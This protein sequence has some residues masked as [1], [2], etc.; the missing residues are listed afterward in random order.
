MSSDFQTTAHDEPERSHASELPPRLGSSAPLDSSDHSYLPVVGMEDFSPEDR[1]PHPLGTP[2]LRRILQVTA[3]LAVLAALIFVPPLV[4]M[5]HYRRQIASSISASL[6]RPV[7]ID[8]VTLNLLPIPGFTLQNF[9]V[10]EDPAY[11]SEPIIRANS[12]TATLRFRSLWRRRVEFSRIV[13][14]APSVN[15]VRLPDGRWNLQSILLQAAHVKAAPTAQRA[16]GEAPRFPYIE[17]TDARVNV[18]FGSEK[19]PISLTEASFALWLP[20]PDRWNLRLNAHPTRTDTA[21]TDTGTLRLEGSLGR[22]TQLR[23]VPINLTASWLNAPLGAV[24]WILLGHDAGI[25]GDLA[26]RAS[27]TGTAGDSEVTSE[28]ALSSVRR[29]EFVPDH[30]LSANVRCTA[31]ATA[32]FHRLD[33]IQCLWPSGQGGGGLTVEGTLPDVTEPTS[34]R[35]EAMITNL[36]ADTLLNALKAASARVDRNLH[37]SGN[38]YGHIVYQEPAAAAAPVGKPSRR[39]RSLPPAPASNTGP[40]FSGTMGIR[41]ADLALNGSVPFLDSD[42]SATL[43][44]DQ[45]V[46]MPVPLNLGAS[47]PAMLSVRLD[48]NGYTLRLTGPLLRSR[49]AQLAHSL[50]Q[51]GDGLPASLV[52]APASPDSNTPESV[53]R[54]DL[55]AVRT[56]NGGQ[57]WVLTAPARPPVHRRVHRIQ[58]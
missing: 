19:L 30:T 53:L 9:I 17:A 11:G 51:F 23:D 46:L 33:Q 20:Q 14:D 55:D 41:K 28:F 35:G 48:R 50:P 44:A 1:D 8:S 34:A 47:A 57:T 56:L 27:A 18:K 6:G 49:L 26:L 39:T 43:S 2:P 12:V 13:L 37:A 36:P 22:G 54:V 3:I 7:R 16:A 32:L 29:A 25:R 21:A 4:S 38:A 52:P 15:L 24:S 42:V 5:N 45:L 58:P 10:G 40:S 31:Q